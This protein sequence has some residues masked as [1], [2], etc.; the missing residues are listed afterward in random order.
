MRCRKKNIFVKMSQSGSSPTGFICVKCG[1]TDR[2]SRRLSTKQLHNIESKMISKIEELHLYFP[3][4]EELKKIYIAGLEDRRTRSDFLRRFSEYEKLAEKDLLM[5]RDEFFIGH[6][7]TVKKNRKSWCHLSSLDL[8]RTKINDPNYKKYEELIS[9]Y[10]HAKDIPTRHDKTSI[11]KTIYRELVDLL[12]L[13]D[14]PDKFV[15][16]KI[17]QDIMESSA[18]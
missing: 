6:Y 3:V 2:K 15:V 8:R 10:A 14:W 17:R 1:C 5:R 13:L 18:S 4:F 16:D 11:L 9:I 12:K 7:N